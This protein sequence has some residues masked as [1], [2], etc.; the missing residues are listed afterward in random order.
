MKLSKLTAAVIAALS[1]SAVYAE[2]TALDQIIVSANHSTQDIKSVT[3][4]LYIITALEIE[5]KGYLSLADALKTIPGLQVVSNG[6]FG[7]TTSLFTRG[8]KTNAT[9]ILIDGVE[10]TDPTG[11]GGSRLGFITLDNVERIEILLGAQSGIW[12]GNASA[13]VVNIITKTAS[14]TGEFGQFNIE[15]GSNNTTRFSSTF[16]A[17]SEKADFSVNISQL[18]SDSYS[19]VRS[20]NKTAYEYENDP[21]SEHSMSFKF[22]VNTFKNQRLEISHQQTNASAEYDGTTDPEASYSTDYTNTIRKVSYM[23]TPKNFNISVFALDNY[24]KQY[25]ESTSLELGLKGDYTYSPNQ[26]LSFLAKNRKIDGVVAT[27]YFPYTT[28]DKNS[29]DVSIALS[30]LNTLQSG[31][32]FITESIRQDNFSNFKNKLTGKIGIKKLF[33]SN[34]FVS[35]NAGTAYNAPTLFQTS[36]GTTPVNLKP[37][38]TE[39]YDVTI[40][41]NGLEMTAYKT[42][43]KNYLDYRSTGYINLEGTS[44]FEGIDVSYKND[45]DTIDSSILASYSILS[46]KNDSGET[47]ARRAD[48]QASLKYDYYGLKN[49]TMGFNTRYI[50]TTYDQADK[51]GVQIGKYFLTDLNASYQL[52]KKFTAFATIKNLFDEQYTTAVSS[53]TGTTANY[54]YSTGGRLFSIGLKG[55]F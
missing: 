21:F 30:N 54:V 4:P 7:K 25:G 34:G 24:M 42:N 23:Y 1:S 22:G 5:E 13:G 2:H 51:Q 53:S 32:L 12:G 52:D 17:K 43:T 27:N 6:G 33:S 39:A 11:T 26:N 49:T 40:G 3:S 36:Y 28:Q 44:K 15:K 14:K 41:W 19:A 37:E 8:Q 46:A 18:Q 50:G 10:M 47:L 9:L 38:E 35:F 29:D 55:N 45:F 16:G 20:A 48:S 31:S